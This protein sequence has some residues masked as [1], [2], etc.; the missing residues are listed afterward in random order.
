[1][2]VSPCSFPREV[3]WPHVTVNERPGGGEQAL[4]RAALTSELVGGSSQT[5][6]H[7]PTHLKH[8]IHPTFYPAT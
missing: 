1:M 3:P 7:S 6:T 8:L 4:S 2:S 5:Q